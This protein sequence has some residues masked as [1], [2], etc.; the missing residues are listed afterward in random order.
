MNVEGAALRCRSL[1]GL[2]IGDRV[3]F[4]LGAVCE[5]LPRR[6]TLSRPDP[7]NPRVERLLAVNVDVVV[8]VVS[9]SSPTRG[10]KEGRKYNTFISMSW[11]GRDPGYGADKR[12]IP[13]ALLTAD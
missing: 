10:L 11:A 3:R 7:H 9:V 2:A 12:D 8:N 5:I 13:S 4:A 6:T 1:P